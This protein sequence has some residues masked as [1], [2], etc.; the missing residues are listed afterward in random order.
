MDT[1][2]TLLTLSLNVEMHDLLHI[3]IVRGDNAADI[4][5]IDE[6]VET[7]RKTELYFNS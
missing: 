4:N 5:D 2:L 1:Q 7:T 3:S 6:A